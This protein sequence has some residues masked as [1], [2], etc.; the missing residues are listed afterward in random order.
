MVG[1]RHNCT[2]EKHLLHN[3]LDG[4]ELRFGVSAVAGLDSLGKLGEL[5]AELVVDLLM[6]VET[7]S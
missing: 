5:V 2:R 1:G 6:N 7:L 3:V 4:T